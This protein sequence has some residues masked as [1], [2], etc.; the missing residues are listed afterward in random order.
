MS[1]IG[2]PVITQITDA[3]V[4][5]TG[6]SLAEIN[7]GTIGLFGSLATPDIVL[8][9]A[10]NPKPYTYQGHVLGIADVVDV[11]AHFVSQLGN[12]R[13]SLAIGK[14]GTTP[15]NFQI[16]IASPLFDEAGQPGIEIY[17]RYHE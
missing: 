13:G 6:I 7:T 1:F 16:S 3:M 2:T 15:Q 5:I 17:V 12:P 11:S 14:T 4:R 10:F 9:E 8:P